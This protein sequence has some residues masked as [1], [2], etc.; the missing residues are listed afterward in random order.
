MT[1]GA[2]T[3]AI[4]IRGLEKRFDGDDGPPVLGA[5]G[6]R[7]ALP[8]FHLF[9]RANGANAWFGWPDVPEVERLRGEWVVQSPQFMRR[10]WQRAHRP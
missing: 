9:L 5:D 10:N 2:A 6:V 8:V 3:A 1:G 7:S 4:A